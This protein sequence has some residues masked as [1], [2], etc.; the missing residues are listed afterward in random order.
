MNPE[1]FYPPLREL[2]NAPLWGPIWFSFFFISSLRSLFW[3]QKPIGFIAF[4]DPP[5]FYPPLRELMKCS[6]MGSH[7]ILFL[8][9][10]LPQLIFLIS[11]SHYSGGLFWPPSFFFIDGWWM[12]GPLFFYLPISWKL[13]LIFFNCF[14][15][16]KYMFLYILWNIR[17]KNRKVL[18]L[19]IFCQNQQPPFSGKILQGFLKFLENYSIYFP[20]CF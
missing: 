8:F 20:L 4:F 16:L 1:I 10:I 3:L 17:G 15:C 6:P 13:L 18:F 9:Y 7:L 19:R 5:I 12:V 14:S 11:K 2:C